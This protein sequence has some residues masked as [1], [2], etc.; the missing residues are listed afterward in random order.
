[1]T[2]RLIVAVDYD[3]T[4]A[5]TNREKAKWIE[6]NLGI[7]VSPWH[8]DRTDCVPIIGEEAYR[9]LGD[10]VYERPSTFFAL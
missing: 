9:R 6:A 7:A 10:W 1:M 2:N 4:I 5:D 3:G 8:C